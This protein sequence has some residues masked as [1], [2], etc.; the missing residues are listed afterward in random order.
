MRRVVSIC[1]L[2][3]IVACASKP[4]VRVSDE[5]LMQLVQGKTAL[6]HAVALLG[7]PPERRR[8]ADFSKL[9]YGWRLGQTNDVNIVP[10]AGVS[11]GSIAVQRRE[12]VL[13]FG[14]DD[15]LR[16]IERR[17]LT[18]KTGYIAATAPPQ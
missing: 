16:E 15:I 4:E 14:T 2:F 5:Q 1:A 10:G 9:V 18:T 17:T 3:M 12:V 11:A 6:S 8:A 13:T 7:E